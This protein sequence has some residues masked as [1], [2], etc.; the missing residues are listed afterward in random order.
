MQ[1][2]EVDI[3]K[4]QVRHYYNWMGMRQGEFQSLKEY[5]ILALRIL[6]YKG[7]EGSSFLQTARVTHHQSWEVVLK[8][9]HH[10]E[11]IQ[12]Y[13]ALT[14]PEGKK[15]LSMYSAELLMKPHDEYSLEVV[16]AKKNRR[17]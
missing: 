1:G 17:R 2:V 10:D 5:D 13:E 8:S 7:K 6:R 12:L 15:F 3:K 11:A 16:N 14:Y 9:E 4:Q